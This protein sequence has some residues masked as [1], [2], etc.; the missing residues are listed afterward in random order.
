MNWL[1]D[2]NLLIAAMRPNHIH[3]ERA[4][5]WLAS[6]KDDGIATCPITEGTLLRMHMVHAGDK[7]AA[8]AWEALAM[9][10]AHPKHVFWPENFSYTEVSPTRPLA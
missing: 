3:H 4:H 10:R 1:L 2:G 9:V 6:I 8:A 7:S 5:Q